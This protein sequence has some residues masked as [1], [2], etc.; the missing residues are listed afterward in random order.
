[1]PNQKEQSFR[2]ILENLHLNGEVGKCEPTDEELIGEI[3]P[4]EV[5]WA[6]EQGAK[7]EQEALDLIQQHKGL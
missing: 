4:D 6:L 7:T 2:P 1:M 5:Q 3:L